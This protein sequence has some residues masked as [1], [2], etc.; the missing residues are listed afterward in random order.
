MPPR[1]GINR[2]NLDKKTAAGLLPEQS[3]LTLQEALRDSIARRSGVRAMNVMYV[4]ANVVNG[5]TITIDGE[6]YE[7]DIINTDS[8]VNTANTDDTG[9]LN[10]TDTVSLVT[11]TAAPGTAISVGDVI[12]I[13]NELLL[14]LRKIST[15]QYVC[16]RAYAG[17]AIATHVKNTDVFVSD[18]VPTNVSIPLVTTLTPAAFAIAF[19]AVFN[20]APPDGESAPARA[21]SQSATFIAYSLGTKLQVLLLAVD[22][23]VNVAATTEEFANSTDNVWANATMVGGK[24][25]AVAGVEASERAVTAAEELAGELHFAFPFAVRSAVV[26]V[27]VTATGQ[28][29]SFT[30]QVIVAYA[31]TTTEVLPSSIVT[32]KN[33]GPAST[34][35]IT[36]FDSTMTVTIIAFE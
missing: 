36:G 9:P 3:T 33:T 25:P 22:A 2:T 21:G 17:S 4:P 32:V 18:S 5:D 15:T 8:S 24:D 27:R 1:G 14:V 7:L 31:E 19:V 16:A 12:R 20:Y 6:T 29:V 26:Q 13:E 28:R 23:G 11:T 30:G 10:A 34:A 35:Y